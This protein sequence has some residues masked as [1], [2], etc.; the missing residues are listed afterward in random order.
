[1]SSEL[2][3][4]D[5]ADSKVREWYCVYHH[6]EAHYFFTNYLKPGFR[7][8]ELCRPLQYGPGIDDVMWLQLLPMFEMMDVE[9]CMDPR[10]PW[11]RCPTAT[12]QHVTAVCPVL[13]VRSWFDI[14]PTTCVEIVKAALGINSF[15]L[16]TPWQLYQYIKAHG[17]VI[18]NSR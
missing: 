17:G 18:N 14:G 4:L 8:V 10:P 13:S 9:V 11:V 1:M 6:R 16:R 12:I 3:L 5:T 2:S 15:L 7:H